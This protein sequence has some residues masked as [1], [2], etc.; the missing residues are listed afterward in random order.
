MRKRRDF[1]FRGHKLTPW[2]VRI[3]IAKGYV[4]H[5]CKLCEAMVRRAR[6]KREKEN[7]ER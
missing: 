7:A 5:Q 4:N 6:R 1:C 3:R 2:N